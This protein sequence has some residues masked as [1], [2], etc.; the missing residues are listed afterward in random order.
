MIEDRPSRTA[1]RVAMRRAVHQLLDHPPVLDD[2]WALTILGAEQERAVREAPSRFEGHP[3]M[4]RFRA[5]LAARS[6]IAEDVLAEC[7]R[8]GVR[9]YVVLG[10]GLDT[11]AYRNPHEGLHVLEVDHP[12]TQAWKRGRLNEVGIVLP[13]TLTL[14]P[15]DF[16]VDDLVESLVAAGLDAARPTFFSWLGVTP[17]LTP[18]T[19]LATLRSVASLA[20]GGGGIA[21]DYMVPESLL[22]P[23]QRRARASL[24]DAVATAGEPFQGALDPAELTGSMRA[25]GYGEIRDLDADAINGLL[26]ADRSD[27]LGVGSTGRIL[28][29]RG[30][31][32]P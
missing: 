16:A 24:S 2:P 25:M 17:Y 14:V 6:R 5:F 28:V 26:F 19:T 7:V 22:T 10:A 8:D 32:S 1:E 12:A 18:E 23:L 20:A 3:V 15:V 27:G 9:Q 13:P 29:A 4:A 11:F 21:F 31:R 30:G